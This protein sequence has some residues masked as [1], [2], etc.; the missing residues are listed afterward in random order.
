MQ[1]IKEREREKGK[2]KI[3]V[4]VF[5]EFVSEVNLSGYLKKKTVSLKCGR[6]IC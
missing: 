1:K 6:I 4:H 2:R 3:H 5:E